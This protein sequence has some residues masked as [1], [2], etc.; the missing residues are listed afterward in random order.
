MRLSSTTIGTG[1]HPEQE[2]SISHKRRDKTV[3]R[4]THSGLFSQRHGHPNSSP[5]IP[6]E[7]AATTAQQRVV[8]VVP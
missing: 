3:G 5:R 2:R 6:P 1:R 8:L 7:R 4:I